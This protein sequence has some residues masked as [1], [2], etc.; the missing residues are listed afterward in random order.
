M[1][2]AGHIAACDSG[3]LSQRSGRV[4]CVSPHGFHEIAYRDWGQVESERL[5]ICLHGVTR[6]GRDFDPLAAALSAT[7]RVICPDLAG[8]GD[9]D[10]L[11][12]PQDYNILQYNMDLV[13]LAASLNA[14]SFDLIGTSLGGLMGIALAGLPGSPIRRLVVNDVAPEIPVAAWNRVAGYGRSEPRFSSMGDVEAHL[15]TTLAPFGPMTD[16]DWTRMAE[17][18]IRQ[19]GD[20][21]ALHYDPA[22]FHHFRRFSVMIA[23]DLWHQWDQIRCPVLIL[24]GRNSDFLTDHLLE[25]MCSRLPHAEVLEFDNVGHTPTLNAH[26]Q[27]DPVLDWLRS[28]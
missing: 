27:I 12:N 10:W 16:A 22:V 14:R 15:R 4:T 13:V 20:A 2:A 9:S 17:N 25:R 1:T 28:K 3:P 24:R 23:F 6:N 11:C 21:I 18:S 8:R 26:V 7:H 19:D 5:A